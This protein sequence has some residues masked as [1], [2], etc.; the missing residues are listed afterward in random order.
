MRYNTG[1]DTLILHISEALRHKVVGGSA[2]GS[3]LQPGKE[4]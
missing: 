3:A 2:F 1:P 4:V